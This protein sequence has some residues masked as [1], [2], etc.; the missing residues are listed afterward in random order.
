[1]EFKQF[2]ELLQK[3]AKV[4]M[5][6]QEY[7]FE[8][9]VDS[10][11]IWNTYLDSFPEG[12][13]EIFRERRE[14]DCSCCRHFVRDLGR[15]VTIK[16]NKVVTIWDFETNDEKYQPVINALSSLVKA[17]S[18]A[19]VY[20]PTEKKVGTEKSRE[21][22]NDGT[23]T[24]YH[25]YTPLPTSV[26]IFRR[27]QIGTV[28]GRMRDVRN[29]LQRSFEEI[30]PE[31][32]ETVLELIAQKSLYK[33]EEWESV[34]SQFQELQKQYLEIT[35]TTN[36][37]NFCW[38]TSV[39]V[40]AVVGKIKNH[41]IGVLLTDISE[42]MDLDAAVR[43]YEAIVAP[44]SYKRPQAIF[45]KKMVQQAHKKVQELGF[46]DS[47]GRRFAQIEDITVNNILFANRN[48]K[49]AMASNVFEELAEA[50][51]QKPKNLSKVEEVG[52]DKFISDIM[53]NISEMELLLENSH[54]GNMVSLIAPTDK[55]SKS[56]LKWDNNFSWGY[57]GNVTDSMKE[58]VKSAG[59]KVDGVLR[60]SIQWNDDKD[61]ED[62]LDAHCIEPN[63]NEIYFSNMRSNTGGNLDVDITQPSQQTKDGVAVE[64]ITWPDKAIMRQGEYKFFV[65][66]YSQARGTKSGFTAEIEFNG[67]IHSFEYAQPLR[68]KENIAVA[69]V[70]FNGDEFTIK[71]TLK[72][73]ASSR[74]IWGLASNSFHPVSVAMHSPNYWDDQQG[75]GNKH[76]FFM[77]NKCS[78]P[79]NVN[80]FFN[81]F[82]Q[83]DLMEHKHVFEA[84]GS[85]MRVADSENQLSGLGFSSTQRAHVFL[86]VKGSFER[87]L[88]VT[89]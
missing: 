50:A 36:K 38:E 63:R 19:N 54:A 60:F 68:Q 4:M 71:E 40:G 85:K 21:I 79:D 64:N 6:D 65:H 57:S 23:S 75:I 76:Y 84:L 82:L 74:E 18:V 43:R 10:D 53:P 9:N 80:G 45:T 69:T 20:I 88:K 73:T 29:V 83:E 1:M 44:S 48:A 67:Q 59:G 56:M 11:T 12:T 17:A 52:I 42:G 22:T 86:K 14:Y 3:H 78:N 66:N 5:K 15:I 55:N 70:M 47:L 13:N 61:N 58:R 26:K 87:M 30:N 16:N 34:L 62:D 32:V 2:N 77:V 89:F 46:E 72:S 7:L 8:V 41:S 49:K 81:E 33:G 28:Q 25:F 24:W 27:D 35:D 39:K 37:E 51:P 31:S